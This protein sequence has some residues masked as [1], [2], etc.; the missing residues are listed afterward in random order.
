MELSI[1][2]SQKENNWWPTNWPVSATCDKLLLILCSGQNISEGARVG[3][4]FG[5]IPIYS[6][7]KRSASADFSDGHL[8]PLSVVKAT[9]L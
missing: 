2:K 4:G 5:L 9:K 1:H 3:L 7:W 6:T 8:P